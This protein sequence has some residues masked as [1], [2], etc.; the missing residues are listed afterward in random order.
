MTFKFFFIRIKK[1][2]ESNNFTKLFSLI[3]EKLIHTF[4]YK[5]NHINYLFRFK[6]NYKIHIELKT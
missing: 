6:L 2:S 3:I 4:F 1:N 5:K